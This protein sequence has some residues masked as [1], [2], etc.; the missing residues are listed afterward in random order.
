MCI[1]DEQHLQQK[2]FRQEAGVQLRCVQSIDE[3]AACVHPPSFR[4][5]RAPHLSTAEVHCKTI[6][7]IVDHDD[8]QRYPQLPGLLSPASYPSPTHTTAHV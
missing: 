4:L 1:G 2:K 3:P 6:T 5:A 8:L 7:V